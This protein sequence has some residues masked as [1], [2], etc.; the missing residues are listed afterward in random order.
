MD[1]RSI[2]ATML[3]TWLKADDVKVLGKQFAP[4]DLFKTA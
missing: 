2:Y 3:K 1:F 4:L